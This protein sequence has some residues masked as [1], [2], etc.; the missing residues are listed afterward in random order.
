M[1]SIADLSKLT[2]LSEAQPKV[3]N[4]VCSNKKQHIFIIYMPQ[5]KWLLKRFCKVHILDRIVNV[6]QKKN[7]HK[8]KHRSILAK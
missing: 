7:V 4:E 6:L 1:H 5:I 8:L 2:A 3:K